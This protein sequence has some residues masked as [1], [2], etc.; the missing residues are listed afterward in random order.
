MRTLD[1]AEEQALNETMELSG[2][3]SIASLR[4]F[5]KEHSVDC[6]VEFIDDRLSEAGMPAP[7]GKLRD[8][9][10]HIV[11]TFIKLSRKRGIY[12]EMISFVSKKVLSMHLGE[13]MNLS[14]KT[15]ESRIDQLVAIG[16]LDSIYANIQN[17]VATWYNAKTGGINHPGIVTI[18]GGGADRE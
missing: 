15:A 12:P 11:N 13:Y 7:G 18:V 10:V 5:V 8:P 4:D 9:F 3:K 14:P 2:S 16:W 1:D 17:P 6:N